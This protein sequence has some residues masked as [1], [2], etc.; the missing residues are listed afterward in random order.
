MSNT[1]DYLAKFER[2][3]RQ[4]E[5][6]NAKKLQEQQ[7]AQ[8]QQ[9]TQEAEEKSRNWWQNFIMGVGEVGEAV[10][11]GVGNVFE[12]IVDAGAN[13]VAGGAQLFGADDV[14]KNITDFS[15]RNLV[16]EGLNSD[17]W[18]G[19]EYFTTSGYLTGMDYED[20][21]KARQE[22]DILAPTAHNILQGVGSGLGFAIPGALG[23]SSAIAG[24]TM[25]T[26]A[27]GSSSTEALNDGADIGEALGYGAMSGTVELLTEKV[28]GG[29]LKKLGV[30]AGNFAGVGK[31]ALKIGSNAVKTG[32]KI[33]NEVGKELLKNAFE[34]GVEE[35]ITELVNPLLKMASYE[36]DKGYG[37]IFQENGGIG[38]LVEAF[39]G[40]T[41]SGGFLGVGNTFNTAK[42][43]N[44]GSIK[45]N[46]KAYNAYLNMEKMIGFNEQG[47]KA[48]GKMTNEERNQI[49]DLVQNMNIM[50]VES[51]REIQ[52][53]NNLSKNGRD[54]LEA[55]I[56]KKAL[57]EEIQRVF[58]DMINTAKFKLALRKVN[59][60]LASATDENTKAK[61]LDQQ[62]NLVE[63]IK[64]AE[65]NFVNDNRNLTN[66]FTLTVNDYDNVAR[67]NAVEV[68]FARKTAKRL[69]GEDFDVE[70]ARNIKGSYYDKKNNKIVLKSSQ[71]NLRRIVDVLGHEFQHVIT[72]KSMVNSLKNLVGSARF[73]QLLKE[74]AK[75]YQEQTKGMNAKDSVAYV[76]EEVASDLFGEMLA[77][78]NGKSLDAV[79]SQLNPTKLQRLINNLKQLKPKLHKNT[80]VN[81]N[82]NKIFK[83]A[84][85]NLKNRTDTKKKETKQ[86]NKYKLDNQF[87]IDLEDYID[88]EEF[89]TIDFEE[90]LRKVKIEEYYTDKQWKKE[91]YDLL[92]KEQKRNLS[93]EKS[94]KRNYEKLIEVLNQKMSSEAKDFFKDTQLR[95]SKNP[96]NFNKQND[97]IIPMFHGTPNNN[98]YFFDGERVGTKGT[99]RG[100]GFYLTSN[101]DYAK[102]YSDGY[103]KV[104]MS[105]V[106][107]KKPLSETKIT[108]SK[109]DLKKF[110]EKVVDSTGDD[111]LSNY[112]DVYSEGYQNV[113]DKAIDNIYEYN[114]SDNGIIEQIF[115]ESRME[116]NDYFPKLT[117]MLGYDGVIFWN[118]SEGTI[119]LAFNSNQIKD[120]ANANPTE[121][122]DIRYKLDSEDNELSKEQQEFFKNSK[123]RDK[124]GRLEVVYHTAPASVAGFTVFD[125]NQSTE[126]YRYAGYYVNFFTDSKTMAESYGYDVQGESEKPVPF[127][128]YSQNNKQSLLYKTYLNIKKPLIINDEGF[129][130]YW[131]DLSK[132]EELENFIEKVGI[133]LFKENE[134]TH[135]LDTVST[136]DF[137]VALDK[138]NN[139]INEDLYFKAYEINEYNE[140]TS[141]NENYLAVWLE[142]KNGLKIKNI[143]NVFKRNG[144]W[145]QEKFYRQEFAFVLSR[146]PWDTNDIVKWAISKNKYDGVVFENIIDYGMGIVEEKES[147]LPH[148]VYVTIKSP[149]QIKDVRNTTP[150]EDVDIRYKLDANKYE[151]AQTADDFKDLLSEVENAT[152]LEIV[153]KRISTVMASTKD[154]RLKVDLLKVRNDAIE[155]K[156]KF[157]P[158]PQEEE[159]EQPKEE[160]KVEEAQPQ[161]APK[162]EE[163]KEETRKNEIS[164]AYGEAEEIEDA[165][166]NMVKVNNKFYKDDF[167][168]FE[169]IYDFTKQLVE[170]NNL[171]DT[172]VNING[173]E[174]TI[175]SVNK[176][177]DN[178]DTVFK[179]YQEI[180]YLKKQLQDTRKEILKKYEDN[181]QVEDLVDIIAET[182]KDAIKVLD[183]RQ[184]S[185]YESK[186]KNYIEKQKLDLKAKKVDTPKVQEKPKKVVEAVEEKPVETVKEYVQKVVYKAVKGSNVIRKVKSAYS[187][188]LKRG[189]YYT[190]SSANRL[191]KLVNEYV[192]GL[193]GAKQDLEMRVQFDDKGREVNVE[194]I[195]RALNSFNQNI[196]KV[197][198]ILPIIMP[199]VQIKVDGKWRQLIDTELKLTTLKNDVMDNIRELAKTILDKEAKPTELEKAIQKLEV[200]YNKKYNTLLAENTR[201]KLKLRRMN[202][203]KSALLETKK[204]NVKL[205][206]IA[207][208]MTNKAVKYVT[209]TDGQITITSTLRNL[210]NHFAEDIG[211]KIKDDDY[212]KMANQLADME[213]ESA[214]KT[215]VD[216]LLEHKDKDGETL[217][218]LYD[219]NE[220]ANITKSVDI[221]LREFAIKAKSSN[222][223][224]LKTKINDLKEDIRAVQLKFNEMDKLL[225]K[226][227][228]LKN[229]ST[230]TTPSTYQQ[231]MEKTKMLLKPIMK[232]SR[233]SISNTKFREAFAKL[234]E[235]YD[236]KTLEYYGFG[237]LYSDVVAQNIDDITSITGK[238][239]T[240]ELIKANAVIS[241][242][243]KI[244]KI[245]NGEYEL[246]LG[247]LKGKVWE[248]SQQAIKQQGRI[249]S[250]KFRRVL[251]NLL[252]PRVVMEIMDGYQE[253]GFFTEF[254]R[255]LEQARNNEVE[256][257]FLMVEDL[258]SF[259]SP[260]FN[261]KDNKFNFATTNEG[262]KFVKS[263][264][265]K[266]KIKDLELTKGEWLSFLKILRR[267]QGRGHLLQSGLEY[268]GKIHTFI[269][270]E[271]QDEIKRL[272]AL[273]KENP[274]DAIT[275][276][277]NEFKEEQ[278][279]YK[280][281][282]LNEYEQE[283][284]KLFNL[285]DNNSVASKYMEQIDALLRVAKDL[286]ERTD[287]AVYGI[288]NVSNDDNYFPIRISD[289]ELQASFDEASFQSGL[290]NVKN[291]HF[292]KNVVSKQG[293]ISVGNI[294][295]TIQLHAKQ[296]AS[297]S[298]YAKPISDFKLI[299]NYRSGN[300]LSLGGAVKQNVGNEFERYVNELLADVQGSRRPGK[301]IDSVV[302]KWVNKFRS[303]FAKFSLFFNAKVMVS[304]LSSIPAA[305]KYIT[306]KN[307]A[308]AV[309][310]IGQKVPDMP[311]LAKYRNVDGN[312]IQAETLSQEANKLIDWTGNGISWADTKA[313]QFLWRASLIQTK[314]ADGSY[315]IDN[316]SELLLKA[317]T[318]TQPNYDAL[319]KSGVLRSESDVTKMFM[320][321]MTQPL[322]NLSNAYEAI[323]RVII[324]KQ[325]GMTVSKEDYK[326]IGATA[327]S[328]FFQGLC[329]S[330]IAYLFKWLRDEDKEELTIEKFAVSFFNDNIIGMFP[331]LNQ[332]ELEFDK[333]NG[334]GVNL[335]EVEL[336]AIAQLND[337]L[338]QFNSVLNDG[339]GSLTP[340]EWVET[341]GKLY[342]VPTRNMYN[343][344]VGLTKKWFTNIYEFEAWYKGYDISQKNNVNDA[345]KNG[346]TGKAKSFYKVFN[347]E[348]VKLSDTTVDEMF[349]LY[350]QYIDYGDNSVYKNVSLRAIP[351]FIS[352]DG[353]EMAVDKD[354]WTNHYSKV[355]SRLNRV[356]LNS[357]YKM[358]TDEE[359]ATLISKVSNTYYSIARKKTLGES[360]NA[361]EIYLDNAN[362]NV[363]NQLCYLSEISLIKADETTTR[364]KLVEKYINK[365]PISKTEKYLLYF[366]SGYK[367]SEAQQKDVESLLRQKGINTRSIKEMFS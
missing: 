70:V 339:A 119:A 92:S 270:T 209:G 362:G 201:L 198:K 150:T 193:V 100:H 4:N 93:F 197:E 199:A 284:I 122:S 264:K 94:Y 317:V 110:I 263:L 282:Q 267:E 244:T 65:P 269:D 19:I 356:V 59:N 31:K 130:R 49:A 220:V 52:A 89:D 74:Q 211:F 367:L 124:Y 256:N 222:T 58:K 22:E 315:N 63:M 142:G 136:N 274:T 13:L 103:G 174:R 248:L 245:A 232:I 246:V 36:Q 157:K 306:F 290:V 16:D 294:N 57:N 79:F 179:A 35:T 168:G 286:K 55:Q 226:V 131:N 78:E 257:Y 106:N 296:M 297:Y 338:N 53:N 148:N 51:L 29:L 265:E 54:Y 276:K 247:K 206:K 309:K 164:F 358:L 266:V 171:L 11:G 47:A 278:N 253:N 352:V 88:I 216:A 39:L 161:E 10:L 281:Q 112:G 101:Y 172:V 138:I 279:A 149:N 351:D 240:E 67:A 205:T 111:W 283:I 299:Y 121:D 360:M 177:R 105:F 61:L 40:G 305:R 336:G 323:S 235:I 83:L 2:I 147:G 46:L 332:F 45:D 307:M 322:K 44:A 238:V 202:A 98:M 20:Y 3:R 239:S 225:K 325:N 355:S 90:K 184:T 72:S 345:L 223:V 21:V 268:D 291:Y 134:D 255:A 81:D 262:K 115:V 50:D 82:Y 292:N 26:S 152:E 180:Q 141:E 125:A 76:A 261:R 132:P 316:A 326:M 143:Y 156:S 319:H 277:I 7:I 15:K 295:Q 250:R 298:A 159:V 17:V 308:K 200:K 289:L 303:N 230:K 343:N 24:T 227:T 237:S 204:A 357:K 354:L 214:V 365:L 129:R 208:K 213:I 153:L 116:Y 118:R 34:E 212:F 241:A 9:K 273:N 97:Y 221:I 293:A 335:S 96:L 271:L 187:M 85:E 73:N 162:E 12:G 348:V 312:I 217:G 243:I 64:R 169:D 361:F 30:G 347:N 196:D 173:T 192:R 123:V 183:E 188:R 185:L 182:Y 104:I 140:T 84:Q 186:H 203:F 114:S 249:K 75:V 167:E 254:E 120:I 62:Q 364:K 25:F 146:M 324:K 41:V 139:L 337:V 86:A 170:A 28:T 68:E 77:K 117:K 135:F 242:L 151:N 69:F 109:N 56:N 236:E 32:A 127:E 195:F 163:P 190:Q 102:S 6:K 341:F 285:S 160:P 48:I 366:L 194:K 14:A 165:D 37:E 95:T 304:Q 346:K 228:T 218:S 43:M 60:N 233:T 137:Q 234:K 154:R 144:S 272:T 260:K 189:V 155:M 215:Y 302:S 126:H 363:S 80:T 158:E 8:A 340:Q 311:P 342:G 300:N 91:Q 133:L 258:L 314:N 359:K 176:T 5:L 349:R 353:V 99:Q 191:V 330:L 275:D 66:L 178:N 288:S 327:S 344:T 329:Y 108:I 1:N 334:L 113:L 229:I 23:A 331:L 210:L 87:V 219:E 175:R 350:K 166:G 42:Q 145:I 333:E 328:L 207:E 287:M 224:V 320:M 27:L 181:E 128:N 280:E 318:E 33:T 321:F 301:Q 251:N 231:F 259:A 38:G 71:A 252:D 310:L 18:K 107:I 313:I